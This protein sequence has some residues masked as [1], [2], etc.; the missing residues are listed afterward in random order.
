[1]V[2]TLLLSTPFILVLDILYALFTSNLAGIVVARSIHFQFYAW[3][4]HSL[5]Y[6]LYSTLSTNSLKP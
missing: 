3:Y 6:L 2:A 4:Y 1:M 5:F